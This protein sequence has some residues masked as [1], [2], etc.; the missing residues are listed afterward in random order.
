MYYIPLF[1][2]ILGYVLKTYKW[3]SVK[4]RKYNTFTPEM[5]FCTTLAAFKSLSLDVFIMLKLLLIQWKSHSSI[6]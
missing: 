5:T 3:Y 2:S 1:F 6:E 4:Y